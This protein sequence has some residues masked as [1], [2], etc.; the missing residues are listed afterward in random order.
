MYTVYNTI[1]NSTDNFKHMQCKN[2]LLSPG[3]ILENRFDNICAIVLY[4]SGKFFQYLVNINISLKT[5]SGN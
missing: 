2:A 4:L 3:G 1:Y 5:N